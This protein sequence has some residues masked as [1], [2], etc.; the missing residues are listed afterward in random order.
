MRRLFHERF[1]STTIIMKI[2]VE[3]NPVKKHLL[4]RQLNKLIEKKEW[5]E[6][7]KLTDRELNPEIKG[8]V[9]TLECSKENLAEVPEFL[10][11]RLRLLNNRK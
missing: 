7:G 3:I 9:L 4:E 11:A 2:H 5:H 1:G 10:I 6:L 8:I